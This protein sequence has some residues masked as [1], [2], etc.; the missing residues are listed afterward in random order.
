MIIDTTK[1]KAES[2]FQLADIQEQL[3][4]TANDPNLRVGD[5]DWGGCSCHISPPCG[6]CTSHAECGLCNQ[7][8]LNDDMV[9][10]N[11]DWI[12][13]ECMIDETTGMT[14]DERSWLG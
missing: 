13:E 14:Q 3:R 5:Y 2:N 8:V 6:Y 11:N 7:T 10:F 9:E 1:T 12:C 4:L